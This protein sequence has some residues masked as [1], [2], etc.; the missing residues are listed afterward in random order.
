MWLWRRWVRLSP[1]CAAV[2]GVFRRGLQLEALREFIISQG[3]SKNVTLQVR[4][5]HSCPSE[6]DL[7]IILQLRECMDFPPA[8]NSCSR[9]LR[10]RLRSLFWTWRPTMLYTHGPR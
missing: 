8:A 2:Q 5:A 1:V 9:G 10:R 7:A 6:S 4:A 3:A